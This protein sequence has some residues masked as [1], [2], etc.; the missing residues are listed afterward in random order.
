MTEHTPGLEKRVL[1]EFLGTFMFVFVGAG[2]AIGGYLV[3]QGVAGAPP[4]PEV[5]L[6]IA[7]LGNGIGLG[8]AISSTIRVSG[9]ALNPAVTIG[10]LVGNRLPPK[11]VIPYILAEVFGA[12]FAVGLM[13][14]VVPT[15]AGN[16]ASVEWGAPISVLSTQYH[17]TVL[18]AIGLEAILTFFLVFVV[19]GAI[20]EAKV[21]YLMG[22]SVGLIVLAD[23]FV[24]AFLTGAAMNP[25]MAIGPEVIGYFLIGPNVMS[26]WYVFWVGPIIG[27]VIAGLAW[28]VLRP[29]PEA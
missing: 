29:E 13:A 18:Q 27:G 20:V 14:L 2:S 10:L 17:Q 16:N 7:A 4:E 23:V 12:I 25:A 24:G 1:A 19:Y 11:D 9:G 26:L 5:G 28:R 8:V 3:A 21:P 22:L 15:P 6:L